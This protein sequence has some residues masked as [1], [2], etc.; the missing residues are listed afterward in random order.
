MTRVPLELPQLPQ[1]VLVVCELTW[2]PAGH[3]LPQATKVP[4]GIWL[5]V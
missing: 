5:Q 3:E 4:V 1:L 2:K